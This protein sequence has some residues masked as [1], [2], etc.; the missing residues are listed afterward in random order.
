MRV[1]DARRT[2][3]ASMAGDGR[4]RQEWMQKSVVGAPTGS[5]LPL[6]VGAGG[7]GAPPTGPRA[8]ATWRLGLTPRGNASAH[9][10]AISGCD[11]DPDDGQRPDARQPEAR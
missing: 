7:L 2:A 4:G 1:E 9:K 10:A 11:P 8:L 6:P 3:D 5:R